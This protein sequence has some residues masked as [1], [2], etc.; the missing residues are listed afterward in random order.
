M[1]ILESTREVSA[2]DVDDSSIPSLVEIANAA[3]AVAAHGQPGVSPPISATVGR[4]DNDLDQPMAA[5]VPT[6]WSAGGDRSVNRD[7]LDALGM[8]LCFSVSYMSATGPEIVFAEILAECGLELSTRD[9]ELLSRD[10]LAEVA[11][12]FGLAVVLDGMP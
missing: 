10:V 4:A 1:N 5:V 11:V 7:S 2:R 9:G 12:E 3:Y 6:C 8:Q